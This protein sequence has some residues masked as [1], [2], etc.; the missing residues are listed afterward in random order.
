MAALE[1]E[2]QQHRRDLLHTQSR[3]ASF[4]QQHADDLRQEQQRRMCLE[5]D[6]QS[7]QKLNLQNE[8]QCGQLSKKVEALEAQL[9]QYRLADRSRCE[10]PCMQPC[11]YPAP[12]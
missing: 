4:A 12:V 8:T 11:S 3:T 2:V 6:H 1:G 7:L 5:E 10:S 9:K